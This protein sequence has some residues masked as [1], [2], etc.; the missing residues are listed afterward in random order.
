MNSDPLSGRTDVQADRQRRRAVPCFQVNKMCIGANAAASE[1]RDYRIGVGLARRQSHG[2]IVLMEQS[3]FTDQDKL[4]VKGQLSVSP[5]GV[6]PESS[7][8]LEDR[9]VY[10]R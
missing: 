5:T 9:D 2:E 8:R 6:L 10:D 7:S 3:G 4:Q 1:T